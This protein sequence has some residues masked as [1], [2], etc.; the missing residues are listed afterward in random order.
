[1][2]RLIATEPCSLTG[3]DSDNK[4][5]P[6]VNE[7]VKQLKVDDLTQTDKDNLKSRLSFVWKESDEH[8]LRRGTSV[9]TWRQ[10]RARRTYRAIQEADNHLF[11]AVLLA[12]PPTECGKTRFDNT[13]EYLLKLGD[14]RSYHMELSLATKRFFESTAA[15]QGLKNADVSKNTP[16]FA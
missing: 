4:H 11:L 10:N 1:M 6:K 12:I 14:Y 16:L 5:L 13:T 9:T 8:S 15:E 7:K 2:E 3:V